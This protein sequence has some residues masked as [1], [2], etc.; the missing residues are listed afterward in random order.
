MAK[1]TTKVF[2][3]TKNVPQPDSAQMMRVP[4]E[5]DFPAAN[6]SVGDIIELIEVPAGVIAQDWDAHF[7]DID[8]NGSP[9][10]AWSIGVLNAAST[11]LGTSYATGQTAGQ[12]NAVVRNPNTDISQA[13][14][15]VARRLG[16]KITAV[17]ATYAG[18]T[19]TGVIVLEMR[20]G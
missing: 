1:F 12:S 7:P 4:I 9:T 19:K 8:S 16:L 14:A 6:Y 18:A 15:T 5:I 2:A 20:G 11:D 17:C 3:K 10:F 13:D